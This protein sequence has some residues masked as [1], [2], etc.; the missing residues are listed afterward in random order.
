ML[1]EK[2]TLSPDQVQSSDVDAVR[3]EGISD[4]AIEDAIH[5]TVLF[6]IMDRIADAL[7]FAIPSKSGFASMAEVLLKRGY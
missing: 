6:N 2:L 3:A 5:V 7:E 4:E 1:V